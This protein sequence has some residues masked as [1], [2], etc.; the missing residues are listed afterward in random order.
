[1]ARLDHFHETVVLVFDWLTAQIGQ[2]AKRAST[3]LNRLKAT[4]RCHLLVLFVVPAAVAKVDA[5]HKSNCLVDDDQLL[6]V[7]PQEN[8]AGDV[9]RMPEHFDVGMPRCQLSLR[10]EAVDAQAH[11]HFLVE[12]HENTNALLLSHEQEK[13]T[14]N[15]G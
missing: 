1:M 14:E 6:V 13:K 2:S 3:L 7:S 15:V 9:V 5:A 11:L 10:V 8:A 4:A 12:Q